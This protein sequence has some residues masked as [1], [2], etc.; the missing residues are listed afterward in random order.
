MI[1]KILLGLFTLLMLMLGVDKFYP[2]A[3]PCSVLMEWSPTALKVLGVIQILRGVLIWFETTRKLVA[4]FFLGLMIYFIV[5]H[6]MTDTYDIGGALFLAGI[7]LLI[8]W[9][10]K[11][12][13]STVEG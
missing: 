3:E 11:F 2:I 1:Y 4:G 12:L 10:P 9:N 13:R 7:C 5:R 8:N 6:L